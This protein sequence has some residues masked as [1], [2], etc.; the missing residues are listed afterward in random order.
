MVFGKRLAN[1][2]HRK[3]LVLSLVDSDLLQSVE[4][5]CEPYHYLELRPLSET[6]G[7]GFWTGSSR[8]PPVLPVG[9]WPLLVTG[10][11]T[12]GC[13]GLGFWWEGPS[14]PRPKFPSGAP[15]VFWRRSVG[16]RLFGRMDALH[17]FLVLLLTID[18]FGRH[19]SVISNR[20]IDDR[21]LNVSR[22]RWGRR[23]RIHAGKSGTLSIRGEKLFG[24]R[25]GIGCGSGC[26]WR[27][28][29]AEK[30]YLLSVDR[31]LTLERDQRRT[32]QR[33]STHTTS[34]PWFVFVIQWRNDDDR[35][36][37]A[38]LH[39]EIGVCFTIDAISEKNRRFLFCE[40]RRRRKG[41]R[42]AR[43]LDVNITKMFVDRLHTKETSSISNVILS[44]N[45]S[46]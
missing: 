9:I 42:H 35:W 11:V 21:L 30:S 39:V 7:L 41:S 28:T 27:R 24:L 3:P 1:W 38:A 22:S 36:N 19:S 44:L 18:F 26:V 46:S 8:T 33:G 45:R 17:R 5:D 43:T 40:Y 15:S 34:T 14:C 13:W 31:R 4:E 2:N 25:F 10:L 29:E 23:L 20:S 12:V 6:I 32:V 16:N 37:C